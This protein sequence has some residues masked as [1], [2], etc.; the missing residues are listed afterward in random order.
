MTNGSTQVD[1]MSHVNL[2]YDKDEVLAA[3]RNVLILARDQADMNKMHGFEDADDF[4]AEKSLIIVESVRDM[5]KNTP[6]DVT[7]LSK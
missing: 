5:I 3:F 6:E 4:I 2:P 1:I 7:D